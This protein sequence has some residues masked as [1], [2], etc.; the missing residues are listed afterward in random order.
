MEGCSNRGVERPPLEYYVIMF[1]R[2]GGESDPL[3]PYESLEDANSAGEF[4]LCG[5][6]W[7]CYEIE[8]DE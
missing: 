3:G 5:W 7:V 2:D 4:H 6:Q 1:D 8:S